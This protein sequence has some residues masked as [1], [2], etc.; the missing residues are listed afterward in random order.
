[1][2]NGSSSPCQVSILLRTKSLAHPFET[3]VYGALVNVN[4]I[5]FCNCPP[6]SVPTTAW[7]TQRRRQA[8]GAATDGDDE[9]R[10]R[11]LAFKDEEGRVRDGT[12]TYIPGHA[13]LGRELKRLRTERDRLVPA[14]SHN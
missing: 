5:L 4:A 6:P 8:T 10:F 7:P 2:V 11:H 9:G 13:G 12:D 3:T 14:S 1:M